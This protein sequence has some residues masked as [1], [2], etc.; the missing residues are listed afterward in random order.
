MSY[1]PDQCGGSF[2][3]G[4]YGRIAAALT[5]RQGHSAYNL[6]CAATAVN[7]PSGLTAVQVGNSITINCVDN[8][9]NEIGYL[10]E[11]STTSASAGFSAIIMG[12]VAPDVST[13]SDNSISSS[14]NYW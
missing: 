9:T 2:T 14:T 13:Y 3:A 12:G 1:Y 7:A 10:I 11:R 6:S 8:A 4:Q 5:V